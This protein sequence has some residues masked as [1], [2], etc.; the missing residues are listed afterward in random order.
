MVCRCPWIP[1]FPGRR[2]RGRVPGNP[3]GGRTPPR[4]NVDMLTLLGLLC[5]VLI[6]GASMAGRLD[7]SI[8]RW[9][10]PAWLP[11]RVPV[12][13]PARRTGRPGLRPARHRFDADAGG[14]VPPGL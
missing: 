5:V 2:G 4:A 11:R 9:I 12:R 7:L 10:S 14:P 8:A 3:T 13:V 6:L 1:E